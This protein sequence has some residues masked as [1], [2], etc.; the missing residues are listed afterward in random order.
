[1]NNWIFQGKP[2]TKAQV[3][4]LPINF[5]G[6]VYLIQNKKTGKVYIGKKSLRSTTK[7]KITKREIKET[8]TRKR[9]R[10]I[11]KETNWQEYKSSSK[12]LLEDF[13]KYGENSFDR[14]ILEFC[15]DK[16]CLTYREVWW[17]FKYDVLENDTYNGNIMGRFFKPKQVN[18]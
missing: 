9:V 2:L 16:T 14:I 11:V 7:T 5:Y 6:F 12:E 3:K 17:Q 13:E 10:Y 15:P 4:D 1:M 8:K 18:E